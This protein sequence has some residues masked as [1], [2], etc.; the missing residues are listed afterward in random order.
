MANDSDKRGSTTSPSF[1][2]HCGE[3]AD[4]DESKCL[5]CSAPFDRASDA[6]APRALETTGETLDALS[7]TEIE[8]RLAEVVPK[9]PSV[10][11][12][13]GAVEEMRLRETIATADLESAPSIEFELPAAPAAAPD[14]RRHARNRPLALVAILGVCALAGLSALELKPAPEGPEIDASAWET[15]DL[16]A[17]P[18]HEGIVGLTDDNKEIVLSLCFQLSRHANTECR[19]SHLREIGEFP[20]R[21]AQFPA[22]SVDRFEISNGDWAACEAA[23]GCAERDIDGCTLYS[24][25][26]GRELR[27]EVPDSMLAPN[28]PAVCVT[29]AEAQAYCEWRGGRLPNGDEWERVARSGDDRLQPWGPF[30]LPGLL[31]WGERILRD[32][33]IPGR[34]DGFE[35]T[36]PVDE[37]RSGATDDGVFNLLG[38]VAEWVEP[39]EDGPDG[40]AAI[41]GG[42]YVT[43]F[44]DL[45]S[46]FH[47]ARPSTER[48]STIGFRCLYP[49]E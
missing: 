17:L 44:Q 21:D 32:F 14:R 33:P 46:T 31:N 18:A 41:R 30:A 40:M 8:Q 35:L 19:L 42:S 36:A 2:P 1:C 11:M 25:A 3:A 20:A 23:G 49:S 16:V 15:S 24:V 26:R 9:D 27:A 12:R 4:A 37:Y 45:R 38:N 39:A 47:V 7:A 48:R 29:F 13:L 43:E 5:S 10:T 28:L 22:F 34:V 6:A